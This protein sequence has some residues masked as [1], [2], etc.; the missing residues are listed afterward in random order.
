MVTYPS[1]WQLLPT[2]RKKG[3]HGKDFHYVTANTEV[4]GWVIERVTGQ[5][6]ADVFES[7]IWQHLGAERDAFYTVDPHGKAVAGGGLNAT[8]RD[9]MRLALM[10]AGKGKFNGV[11]IVPEAAIAR[12]SAGGTPR[13]SLWG[14]ENGGSDNSY[15]SQWYYHH[16]TATLFANGV[17]GQTIHI[18]V[19]EDVVM[20]MQSSHPQADDTFFITSDDFFQAIQAYLRR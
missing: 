8:A 2:L 15:V 13:P 3:E 5:S 6:L 12:I 7:R 1:L 14:N 10:V 16:P 18:A 4:L 20:V 17:H 11:Q 9:S 19:N